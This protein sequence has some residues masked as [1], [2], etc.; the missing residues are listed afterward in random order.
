MLSD[1]ASGTV[2]EDAQVQVCILFPVVA[3]KV[4]QNS[5][6]HQIKKA[7]LKFPAIRLLLSLEFR[8]L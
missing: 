8:K 4:A 5:P 1:T 6:N 3:L 2:K 7:S